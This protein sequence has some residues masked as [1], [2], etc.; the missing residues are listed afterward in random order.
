MNICK[1][2]HH[3]LYC[4]YAFQIKLQ[5]NKTKSKKNTLQQIKNLT[6]QG[7]SE[8]TFFEYIDWLLF[9]YNEYN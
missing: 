8:M 7:S 6:S 9:V 5:Q 2:K 1:G 4:F 3:K